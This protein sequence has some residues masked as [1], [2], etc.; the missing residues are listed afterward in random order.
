M[1]GDFNNIVL[2]QSFNSCTTFN[3][4]TVSNL[5]CWIHFSNYSIISQGRKHF[6]LLRW[7]GYANCVHHLVSQFV[8]GSVTLANLL[9]TKYHSVK[10]LS[11][12]NFRRHAPYADLSKWI[13]W[14][15][16]YDF[17]DLNNMWLQLYIYSK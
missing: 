15:L 3:S 9:S 8:L 2:K 13:S 17:K 4:C 11:N 7:K 1:Y 6:I 12:M 5:W 10:E 16:T 14:T